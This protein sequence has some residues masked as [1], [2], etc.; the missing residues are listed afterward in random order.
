MRQGAA[1]ALSLD[2]TL[3]HGGLSFGIIRHSR[4][5]KTSFVQ[6]VD[7]LIVQTA[8]NQ[9]FGQICR[10]IRNQPNA[11]DYL[12]PVFMVANSAL[13]PTWKKEV[14][15]IADL[16]NLYSASETARLIHEKITR[17]ALVQNPPQTYEV[18][19]LLKILQFLF[20][21][22]TQLSPFPNRYSKIHYQ[23]PF[24]SYFFDENEGHKI[25][26]IIGLGERN[27]WVTGKTLDKIHGCASCGSAHQNLRPTCPKC[28]SVDL[29]EEDLVHHFPCAHIAPVSDFERDGADGLHCPK[30]DKSLRHIGNDY[31]KPSSIYTCNNC[32]HSFQQSAYKSLCIDCGEDVDLQ[33][34]EEKDIRQVQLTNK[35][36]SVVLNGTGFGKVSLSEN[37][38]AASTGIFDFDIFKIL[39]KQELA[40]RKSNPRPGVLGQVKIEGILADHMPVKTR[41]ELTV[42]VCQVIRSYLKEP[43]VVSARGP[44]SY[45]FMMTE[46]GLAEAQYLHELLTFNLKQLVGSNFSRFEINV[47]VKLESMLK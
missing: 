40:Q 43:D 13:N 33:K 7:A 20:T 38:P 34:L 36:K 44:G 4:Q 1:R 23:F 30:C 3:Y 41:E 17:A 10:G 25:L 21:R 15:G 16:D 11:E 24:A 2:K 28:S 14:D 42:E 39:L 47:K 32:H 6:A 27:G 26:E 18:D 29:K 19:I 22:E 5:V 12:K 46:N 37:K 45:Y 31:D 9:E 8:S 35:G